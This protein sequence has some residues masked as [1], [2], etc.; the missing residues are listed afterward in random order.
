MRILTSAS[1]DCSMVILTVDKKYASRTRGER[2]RHQPHLIYTR[3]HALAQASTQVQKRNGMPD[4]GKTLCPTKLIH[5]THTQ[6]QF[7]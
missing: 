3:M 4:S 1:C 2:G 7:I 6:A 5:P